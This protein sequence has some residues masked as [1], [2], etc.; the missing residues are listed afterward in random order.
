MQSEI[1]TVR[2]LSVIFRNGR[3][4][5]KAVDQISFSLKKGCT[6]GI[7]GESGSGKSVTA[8]SLLKLLPA[9]A[10]K[11]SA[12]KIHL[13]DQSG[14]FIDL[15]SMTNRQM[16]DIRGN[17]ISMIFQEPMTSLN[18]VTRCGNQVVEAI[19]AHRQVTRRE[20]RKLT[21][22]LFAEVMLPGPDEIFDAY[23]HEL[24]GGQKQRVMIAMAVASKPDI[25]IADEPTTALDTTVQKSIVQLLKNLQGKF[26]MAI[27]FIT[28]DLAL[29]SGIADELIVMKD[30]K[31]VESGP[32]A[33]IFSMPR[34]PYTRGLLACRPPVDMIPER[35][36]TMEDFIQKNDPEEQEAGILS[37]PR[38]EKRHADKL[39]KIYAQEPLL[40]TT[41]LETRFR[42]KSGRKHKKSEIKAV[43]GVSVRV[44][45]GEVLGLVG[46]SGCGKTTFG[47]SIL[48]LVKPAG[49]KVHYN[50][51]DLMLLPERSMKKLRKDIQIIFQDP[52]SSLNPMLTAGAAITE[53]MMVHGIG[54]DHKERR[55]IAAGILK[56]AGLDETYL[57]R[58]PHELSGG[59]RQRVCIARALA[60]RPRFIVCDESVSA[61]DVSV[62][63]QVLNLLKDLQEEF[64]LTYV[65]ISHDL[66]VVKFI[67]DR[68]A[69]MKKG[70]IVETLTSEEIFHNNH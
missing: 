70:R 14:S 35:L 66:S 21:L 29:I 12:E 67:S 22:D 47:R 17:R 1:L 69:V 52:Y 16:R 5:I 13:H 20:A 9:S 19:R 8:L 56:K 2:D 3:E 43:D 62:Q 46:E 45:P 49:G 37:I 55:E 41:G 64:G 28:H 32:A 44:F 38:D 6:T 27:L 11:I 31:V 50:G 15:L 57:N 61:L 68:I 4:E 60:V 34:H 26:G 58:Y 23:P 18:P 51:E 48:R 59:Q 25:L 40:E 54:K 36:P 33:M 42:L 10:A 39:R 30:G 7:V 63:A 53:P 65:F 24:S